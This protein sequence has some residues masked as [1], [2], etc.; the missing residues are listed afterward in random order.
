MVNIEIQK[1]IITQ[2]FN[3]WNKNFGSEKQRNQKH[4]ITE[5]SLKSWCKD[6]E[7]IKSES[8]INAFEIS[9]AG[10]GMTIPTPDQYTFVSFS[11]IFSKILWTIEHKT[12]GFVFM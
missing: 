5:F 2:Y 3:I 10:Q 12:V 6:D 11:M 8:I 7:P 1:A 4:K 9:Q